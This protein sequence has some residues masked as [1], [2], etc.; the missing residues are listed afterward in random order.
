MIAM[1]LLVA[2][3]MLVAAA[4]ITALFVYAVREEPGKRRHGWLA[5]VPL[6]ILGGWM[7]ETIIA[8]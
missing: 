5:I 2:I 7:L 3:L 1:A 6:L 4:C 8:H